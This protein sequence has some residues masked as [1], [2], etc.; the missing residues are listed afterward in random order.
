MG[1]IFNYLGLSVACL[2]QL[3]NAFIY[4]E[5]VKKSEEN[6]TEDD[7]AATIS[8]FIVDMDHLKPCSR[9][10][11]YT[12]DVTYGINSEFGF[13][14][15]RDNMV[16]S[17]EEKVQHGHSFAIRDEVDSI[18][19]DEARTPL[20]ISAPN[21]KS[22]D[23]YKRFALLVPQLKENVDYNKDEERH[24]VSLT[25]EGIQ[26]MEQLLGVQNIF[27][28]DV[29]LAH[30]L[31][32]ALK[33]HILYR[34]DKEYV[35]KE[36][37]IVIVDQ[38]TG[39]LMP[40]RRYSQG[41]HQAIEAKENVT[42]NQE[43][44]TLATI[45]IQNYFRMYKKL[46]GM[47]GTAATEAEEFYKIY[48]LEVVV[49]P[50]HRKMVR[51][52]KSD[53]IYKTE[54]GKCI[55]LIEEIKTKYERGQPV[56]VGTISIEK[57]EFLSQ[58]LNKASIP[59]KVLNAKQHESEAAIIAQAGKLK[60]VT[61]ATNMAGRGVDI[62]L[63]G[64]PQDKEEAAKVRDLG[65]LCVLGSE[66]HEARRIDN[67][68][69]GRSGRQGDPGES[70]FFISLDDDL[71]RIFGSSRIKNVMER[72]RVPDDVPIENRLITSSLEKAQKKVEGNN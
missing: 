72:L 43:S 12:A 63:G 14:Y 18:L 33:A 9:A 61:V 41:L 46:S 60:A 67:Q 38:F 3:G 53:L 34:K 40:G 24:A 15:L 57:N 16:Q 49:I 45:T 62:I 51:N 69:R 20:I 2:Q 1:Q 32:Q 59:H 10:E 13:D 44:K 8:T 36:G 17:F 42:V 48:T 50:T 5:T 35:V 21:T 55:A 37:E 19:I 54:Q 71:M 68:L 6:V 4:D 64:N 7:A 47:T 66:R 56:L 28:E 29:T 52:D 65:G 39:R 26:K 31:D 23:L 11:A 58:L 22:A 25:E 27:T 70:R 30:Q